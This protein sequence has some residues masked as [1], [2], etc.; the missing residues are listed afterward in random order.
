MLGNFASDAIRFYPGVRNRDSTDKYTG[1]RADIPPGRSPLMTCS[2]RCLFDNTITTMFLSGR[3]VQELLD[4]VSMR[5][6]ER[7][8]QS[9]AQVA[10]IESTMDCNLMMRMH[11]TF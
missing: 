9:Q 11:E 1:Y 6:T 2:I 8:C 7:G 4:Y 5:S 10:G 3:E